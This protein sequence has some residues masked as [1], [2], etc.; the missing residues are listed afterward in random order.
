MTTDFIL[1][2]Q[3]AESDVD[4]PVLQGKYEEFVLFLLNEGENFQNINAY[5]NAL[6]YTKV[7]MSFMLAQCFE[8]KSNGFS[9]KSDRIS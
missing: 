9:S 3:D 2:I 8:K 4:V 6:I 7:E 1:T 5:F